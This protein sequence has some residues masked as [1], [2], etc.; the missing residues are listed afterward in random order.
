MTEGK[1]PD[2]ERLPRLSPFDPQS[3][4]A[5]NVAETVA[6]SRELRGLFRHRPLLR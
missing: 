2:P 1:A 5:G 6:R 3:G 4:N